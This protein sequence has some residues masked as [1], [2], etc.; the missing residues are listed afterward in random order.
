LLIEGLTVPVDQ[1]RKN[2]FEKAGVW[3]SKI[4]ETLR[5]R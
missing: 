2:G 3:K 1:L 5:K 4:G